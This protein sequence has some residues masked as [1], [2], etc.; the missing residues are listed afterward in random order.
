MARALARWS[1]DRGMAICAW[2]KLCD[3]PTWVSTALQQK[4]TSRTAARLSV[5]T[6]EHGVIA[7]FQMAG[8]YT[9][10]AAADAAGESTNGEAK[11]QGPTPATTRR[12]F[13]PRFSKRPL[14]APHRA[15]RW[16]P[17]TNM[18]PPPSRWPALRPKEAAGVAGGNANG[19]A[20]L[21][22]CPLASRRRRRPKS[23][24][25]N[26]QRGPVSPPEGELTQRPGP[27]A[28]P[29]KTRPAQDGAR[30]RESLAQPHHRVSAA[31]PTPSSGIEEGGCSPV[32]RLS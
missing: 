27:L 21:E 19:E 1:S 13:R 11:C 31:V 6:G 14:R 17:T 8:N 29:E 10:K 9:R 7:T 23:P 3:Y 20:E 26:G 24:A 16:S 25:P 32:K 2:F 4:A 22:P 5:V 18:R 12:G 30:R 15:F 28:P